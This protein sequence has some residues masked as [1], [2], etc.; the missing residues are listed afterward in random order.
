MELDFLFLDYNMK[1][2]KM[3]FYRYAKN[4]RLQKS[5]SKNPYRLSFSE[6]YSTKAN[7]SE[8]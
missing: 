5:A 3:G 8:G 6:V 7:S 2:C 1:I 4:W